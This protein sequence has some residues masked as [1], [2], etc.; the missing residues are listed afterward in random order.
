MQSLALLSPITDFFCG[1]GIADTSLLMSNAN[2]SPPTER[3]SYWLDWRVRALV[4]L[5]LLLHLAAVILPPMSME[6]SPLM[7]RG[8]RWMQ[9]YIEAA[10]LNHGYHFFAP[11]PG[12]SHL[13]RYELELPD[14]SRKEGTFPSRDD[15]W[16]RLLYHRHFMLTE[17][18]NVLHE[19]A[20][21]EADLERDQQ[22]AAPVQTS[23]Y[24][25]PGAEPS[26]PPAADPPRYVDRE[27]LEIYSHSYADHLLA[28]HGAQRVTIRLVRHLIP[29]P[30]DIRAGMPLDDPSLYRELFQKSFVADVPQTEAVTP[31]PMA[32]LVPIRSR[33]GGRR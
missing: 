29:F 33:V 14:G 13:I 17:F 12:P 18:L 1:A 32:S 22:R 27:L 19:N 5:L 3:R 10:Y 11:Q 21:R 24:Y 4:S 2:P 28:R 23:Q 30:D 26:T 6:G 9:P 31:P 20:L 7:S 8:W 15:N 25:P 16:P